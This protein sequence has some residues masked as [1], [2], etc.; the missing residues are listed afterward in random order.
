MASGLRV[1]IG[2]ENAFDH[3]AKTVGTTAAQLVTAE[4]RVNRGV[5]IKAAFGNTGRVYVGN[6]DVTN[7]STDATDGFELSAGQGLFVPTH[8]VTNVWIVGSAA[9]Q[10]T[11]WFGL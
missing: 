8:D 9:D 7:G 11:Y 1:Q 6:A 5:Q 4:T 3:G 2:G 10:K